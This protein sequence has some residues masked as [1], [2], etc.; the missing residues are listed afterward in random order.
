M[1]NTP[2]TT[3]KRIVKLSFQPEKVKDFLEIFRESKYQIRSFP[4]CLHLEL[5][6]NK[7]EPNV[8]FTYSFW[9]N[10]LALEAYRESE[11]FKATW[12]KTKALFNDKPQAWSVEMLDLVV[13]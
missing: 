8:F 5:W 9:E 12:K 6:N 13:N 3:L 1:M 11:L 7:A 10:E 2:K 4:G